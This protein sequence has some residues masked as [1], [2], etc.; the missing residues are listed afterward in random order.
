MM[1][2]HNQ[3]KL[4]PLMKEAGAT[5][6]EKSAWKLTSDILTYEQFQKTLGPGFDRPM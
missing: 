3:E 6:K 5:F 1:T 2:L 4:V